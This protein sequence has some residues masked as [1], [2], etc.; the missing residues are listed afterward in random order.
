MTYLIVSDDGQDDLKS[1]GR[2][3]EAIKDCAAP[4]LISGHFK[5]GL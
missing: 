5:R 3:A 1:A 2:V 4:K